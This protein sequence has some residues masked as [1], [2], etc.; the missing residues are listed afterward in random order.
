MVAVH[1]RAGLVVEVKSAWGETPS[2]D[3]VSPEQLKRL[4]Q[5]AEHLVWQL[6]LDCVEVRLAFVRL[7][8][9][10]QALTWVSLDPPMT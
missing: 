7:D 9:H 10:Q 3:R 4:W 1:Q 6:E 5:I 2:H 8:R